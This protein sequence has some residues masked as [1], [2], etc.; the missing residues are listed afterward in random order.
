[1]GD[2]VPDD[3]TLAMVAERLAR[4]DCRNGYLLDGFPRTIAQA[5]RLRDALAARDARLDVVL[6]LVVDDDELIRRMSERRVLVD[7]VWTQREDDRPETIRHRLRVY[8][9]QTAPL[10]G[11][12]ADEGLLR[13][14][15]AMGEIPDVAGRVL[16]AVD[17][18]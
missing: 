14:V 17:H 15:D 7:G 9:E 2:L 10:A 18:S 16:A 13:P 3:I 5:E 11:F 1:V 12:Y 6:E 4:P 8:R